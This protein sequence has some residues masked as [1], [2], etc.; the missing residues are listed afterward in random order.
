[1]FTGKVGVFIEKVGGST[2]YPFI[3]LYEMI[4]V[5]GLPLRNPCAYINNPSYGGRRNKFCF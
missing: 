1:M 5:I 4:A 2:G 3:M